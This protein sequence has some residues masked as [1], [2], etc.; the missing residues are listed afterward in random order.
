MPVSVRIALDSRIVGQEWAF[1]GS[2][3]PLDVFASTAPGTRK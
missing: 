3:N 1:L 2:A